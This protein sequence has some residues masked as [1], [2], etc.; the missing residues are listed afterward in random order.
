MF[1]LESFRCFE[2]HFILIIEMFHSLRDHITSKFDLMIP[3]SKFL[4]R[5]HWT[6]RQLEFGFSENCVK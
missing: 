2:I 4:G 3:L 1:L 6:A 5:S